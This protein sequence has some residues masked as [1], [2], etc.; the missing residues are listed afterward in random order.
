MKKIYYLFLLLP[1]ALISCSQDEEAVDPREAFVGTWSET[2]NWIITVDGDKYEDSGFGTMTVSKGNQANA[3]IMITDGQAV[4]ATVNGTTF[5]IPVQSI[6]ENVDGT[7]LI[8]DYAGNGR[9]V[10]GQLEYTIT[11]KEITGY[12][13]TASGKATA[14]KVN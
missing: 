13:I 14:S 10:D 12:N 6:S 4:N 5:V 7:T 3:I 9:L 11:M 8:Y 2:Y 1:F